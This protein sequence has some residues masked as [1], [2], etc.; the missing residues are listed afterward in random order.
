MQAGHLRLPANTVCR[1]LTDAAS[2]LHAIHQAG[3]IH[4]DVKP[5][6]LFLTSNGT[7]TVGDFGVAVDAA[8]TGG[9][10]A[11]PSSARRCSRPRSSSFSRSRDAA[12]MST[13]AVRYS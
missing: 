13:R 6:N 2:G 9:R 5:A 12:R 3:D 11:A 7:T 4:R 8:R 1:M 10:G